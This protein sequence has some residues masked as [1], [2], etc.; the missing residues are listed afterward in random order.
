MLAWLL[1]LNSLTENFAGLDNPPTMPPI[2]AGPVLKTGEFIRNLYEGIFKTAKRSKPI[3]F[4]QTIFQ[5]TAEIQIFKVN[6]SENGNS[7]SLEK[8]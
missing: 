4:D 6:V 3:F 1:G 5:Q 8:T 7:V 2:K